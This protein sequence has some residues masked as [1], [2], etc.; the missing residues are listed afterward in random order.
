MAIENWSDDKV[1]TVAI[2][3]MVS[4]ILFLLVSLWAYSWKTDIQEHKIMTNNG[5]QECTIYIPNT[6]DSRKVWQ[7][8]C[9]ILKLYPGTII[10]K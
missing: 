7:K 6:G 9:Q 5:Y 1:T 4:I 3:T 10:K 2:T 8:K